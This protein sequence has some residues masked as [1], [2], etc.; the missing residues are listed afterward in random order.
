MEKNESTSSAKIK[1][2]LKKR[3]MIKPPVETDPRLFNPRKKTGIVACIS[4]VACTAGFSSTIYFPGNTYIKNDGSQQKNVR[5][6][7]MLRI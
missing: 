7:T 5:F 2:Y 6:L 4:L 3:C 1:S